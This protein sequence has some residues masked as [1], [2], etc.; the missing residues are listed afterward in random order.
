MDNKENM[1]DDGAEDALLQAKSKKGTVSSKGGQNANEFGENTA[2]L[3]QAKAE[4]HDK[5]QKRGEQSNIEEGQPNGQGEAV[6]LPSTTADSD[7]KES[8]PSKSNN[9]T[10][11]TKNSQDN[12]GKS[13]ETSINEGDFEEEQHTNG[14]R[15]SVN[16]AGQKYSTSPNSDKDS[17]P[18]LS[19]PTNGN[20]STKMDTDG[21]KSGSKTVWGLRLDLLLLTIG[22]VI[23]AVILRLPLGAQQVAIENPAIQKQLRDLENQFN[24]QF[25]KVKSKMEDL[26]SEVE[27]INEEMKKANNTVLEVRE[28]SKTAEEKVDQTNANLK[29]VHQHLFNKDALTAAI[30]ILFF[31]II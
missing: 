12:D 5:N 18:N 11:A 16:S 14:Q 1:K 25:N 23:A 28:S 21:A 26:K 22:D 13:A 4:E 29:I 6:V 7:I 30:L 31:L 2:G 3:T 15:K 10:I 24:R 20:N 19:E 9:S 8:D 27:A 17:T